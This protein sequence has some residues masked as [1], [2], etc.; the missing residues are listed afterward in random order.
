MRKEKGITLVALVITIIVLIILTA[1]SIRAVLNDGIIIN[2][3][4]AKE[5]WEAGR[6]EEEGKIGSLL[7]KLEGKHIVSENGSTTLVDATGDKLKNYKIHGNT[8]NNTS[9]GDKMNNLFNGKWI[10]KQ[11]NT[12]SGDTQRISSENLIPVK[13]GE[14][15]NFSTNTSYIE[16][17]AVIFSSEGFRGDNILDDTGWKSETLNVTASGDGYLVMMCRFSDNSVITPDDV[18]DYKFT[19]EKV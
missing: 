12:P 13:K 3:K 1:V 8:V 6:T 4:G 9:V 2:A 5:N 18:K 17:V 7:E 15:Y 16:L 10:Q 11:I 19:L 14:T